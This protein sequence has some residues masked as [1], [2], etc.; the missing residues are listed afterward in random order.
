[1]CTFL[2]SFRNL[3]RLTS[4]LKLSCLNSFLIL[5]KGFAHLTHLLHSRPGDQGPSSHAQ[6]S[7]APQSHSLLFYRLFYLGTA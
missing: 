4:N 7:R 3:K 6:V 2:K 5:S 1:M